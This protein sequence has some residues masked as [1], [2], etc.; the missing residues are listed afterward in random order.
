MIIQIISLNIFFC[1]RLCSMFISLSNVSNLFQTGQFPFSAHFGG[2][3]VT[4]ATLNVKLILVYYTSAI[5]LLTNKS[6][7]VKSKFI[8]FCLIG[9]PK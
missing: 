4:I 1:I 8:F 5:V 6:I 3:F 7:L 9:G 2:H